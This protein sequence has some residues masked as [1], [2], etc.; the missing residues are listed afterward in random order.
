MMN[1]FVITFILNLIL[2]T[3]NAQRFEGIGD[4]L[5]TPSGD[6]DVFKPISISANGSVILFKNGKIFRNNQIYNL[7]PYKAEGLFY[8][9]F[10]AYP[11]K[12]SSDGTKIVGTIDKLGFNTFSISPGFYRSDF[13]RVACIWDA[14]TLDYKLLDEPPTI[15]LAPTYY[16]GFQN[17]FSS[18]VTN[19]F[20]YGRVTL[21][22]DY[23][24]V[25]N[26]VKSLPAVWSVTDGRL[27]SF[28][29]NT[30]NNT[31][32]YGFNDV[33]DNN[34]GVGNS[35]PS[36]VSK[37]IFKPIGVNNLT[38]IPIN[39][40]ST[41]IKISTDGKVIFG[42]K[43][44]INRSMVYM[45]KD[46][47]IQDLGYIST[48]IYL[49]YYYASAP[50]QSNI[51]SSSISDDGII[52]INKTIW[53]RIK[54][55]RDLEQTLKNDYNLNLTGWSNLSA[56][57][58]SDDGSIIVGLGINP[59]GKVQA[60]KANIKQSV[61]IK[62]YV[63]K[64]D[65]QSNI[66]Q[67]LL[68]V[69]S[70]RSVASNSI[71]LRV[72]ADGSDVSIFK[73]YNVDAANNDDINLRIREQI[74]DN[75]FD[76][77]ARQYG[78]FTSI[79]TPTTEAGTFEFRY[80]HPNVLPITNNS[81]FQN[82][83]LELYK[84]STNEIIGTFPFEVYR[85][86]VLM[87]HGIWSNSSDAF[88]KMYDKL[89]SSGQYDSFLLLNQNYESTNDELFIVN[90]RVI[91]DGIAN[92]KN[93]VISNKSIAVGKVDVVV[94]SMG[95][96]LTRLYLQS[97]EYINRKDIHKFI[98]CNTPHSGSQGANF[99]RTTKVGGVLCESILSQGDCGKGAVDNLQVDSDAILKDLNGSSINKNIVPSHAIATK[100]NVDD[101]IGKFNLIADRV[102]PFEDLIIKKIP[103]LLSKEGFMS[104]HLAIN[105]GSKVAKD[106]TK[107]IFN[108]EESDLV[109]AL[110]SQIGGIDKYT[111][112]NDKQM[113]S[114]ST[115][116]DEL[117][118]VVRGLLNADINGENSKFSLNGFNP[119]KLTYN[120]PSIYKLINANISRTNLSTRSVSATDSLT[121]KITSPLKGSSYRKGEVINLKAEGSTST[122]GLVFLAKDYKNNNYRGEIIANSG[123]YILIPDNNIQ[124]RM[125]L[126]VYAYDTIFQ[127]LAVDTTYFFITNCPSVNIVGNTT[128][129]ADNSTT[130]TASSGASYL[131]STGEVTAAI[132]ISPTV[133]TTYSVTVTDE[134]GCTA[135][136][137]KAI[138][139][140]PS[141]IVNIVIPNTV[142]CAGQFTRNVILSVNTTGSPTPVISYSLNGVTQ[143]PANRP[144]E[145]TQAPLVSTVYTVVGTAANGCVG[146]DT[147]TMTVNPAPQVTLT[148]NTNLCAGQSTTLTATPLGTG[149]Y[150]YRWNNR[151]ETTPSL[152]VT[153]LT[154]RSYIVTV[155]LGVCTITPS[156]TVNV[157]PSNANIS[158]ELV[159]CEGSS[160][161]LSP[162]VVGTYL[163]ST[164]ETTDVIT[165][166][167]SISTDYSITVTDENGCIA[168]DTKT[169]I[170]NPKPT[171]AITGNLTVCA[172]TSTTLTASGGETYLWNTA[173]T[174]S[175]ITVNPTTS[176]TY[177]VSVTDANGCINTASKTVTISPIQTYY[178]DADGDTFGNPSVTVQACVAPV[179]Y[180]ANSGDCNDNNAAI[181]P[182]AIEIC[183]GID[184]NCN[185]QIDE[186][187]APIIVTTPPAN[188]TKIVG[189]TAT[190]SVSVTG[191]AP[192]TYRWFKTSSPTTAI[193]SSATF[194]VASV[195]LSDAGAYQC[196]I[197]NAC[198]SVLS[199]SANLTVNPAC[200]PPPAPYV[201]TPFAFAG[202]GNVGAKAQRRDA[203]FAPIPNLT[204]E[205]YEY[206][207]TQP[208]NQGALI[209]TQTTTVLEPISVYIWN[210]APLATTQIKKVLV[211]EKIGA[212]YSAS[213]EV[214]LTVF[215]KPVNDLS[216]SGAT[217]ACGVVN[218]TA[219][220]ATALTPIQ[221]IEWW[222]N[223][224]HDVNPA[225]SLNANFSTTDVNLNFAFV[226]KNEFRTHIA[227]NLTCY[228][229]G[230]FTGITVNTIP[231]VS[232][233]NLNSN[234]CKN[235]TPITLTGLP[236]NGT[237][238]I[239]GINAT[240]LDPSVLSVGNHVVMYS[241]TDVNGCSN[242]INQTVTIN[243][244]PNVSITNLN[245]NYC[246]NA[247]VITLTGLP[248]NGSFK[249][250]GISATIL[251]PSV[252]S[253][254]N[255]VITYSYTDANGCS[256]SIN[257][258]V[259]IN[260]L[261]T[262][263][264]TNLN[265]NY[266]KNTSTITL[267]GLPINGSFK[268]DG[269]SATI[270]DPSVLSVG[271]HVVTYSFTDANGCFNSI[272]Q[273]VIINALPTVS[274]TNLNSNYCKNATPITLTGLPIN[275][276][277]KIDG[278]SATILDPSVLSVGNHVVTYSYT[279][280]N[281]CSN[282][283][284][285]T[286]TINAQPSISIAAN[287][288]AICAGQTSQLTATVSGVTT[289][290]T[291]SWDNGL[292]NGGLKTTP[293]LSISTTFIAT[294]TTIAG[295]SAT[296][297]AATVTV[298]PPP[299]TPTTTVTQPASCTAS[300]GT[301]TVTAQSNVEYSFDNGSTYQ[302]SNVKT[303]LASGVYQIKV[304]NLTTG[305]V[306][307]A[308]SATIN[309]P[310][311]INVSILTNFAPSYC[312]NNNIVI[313]IQGTPSGGVFKLDGQNLPTISGFSVI[314]PSNLTVGNHILTYNF[315]QNGCTG[316]ATKT[317]V[318]KALPPKP[319][320]QI[321]QVS[322]NAGGS[323][324]ITNLPAGASSRLNNGVW[325]IGKTNYPNLSA[326]TY[327]VRVLN[328]G[329]EESKTVTLN[330]MGFAYDENKCYKIVN[331][332]SGK[333]LDVAG[334]STANNAPII[335]YSLNGVEG[336]ANQKW[337]FDATE[338]GWLKMTVQHSQKVL[339]CNSDKEG[340]NTTQNNY[341]NSEEREWKI[342]CIGSY[343]RI[344]HRESG[345]Y[346]SIEGNSLANSANV[347]IRNWAN[348][349]SQ[350]WSIVEVSCGNPTNNLVA[351]S[352][353]DITAQAEYDRNRITF[354]T[355]QGF[356]TDYYTLEKQDNS[357]GEFKKL[358]ILNNTQLDYTLQDKSMYDD[359][360]QE[361]DNFYRLKMTY[362]T[363]DFDYSP[364]QKVVN[365]KA[366]GFTIF[367]NPA[368]DE[369]WIDLKTFEGR[370]LEI[371]L[372]DMAGKT[373]QV[374]KV[375]KATALP[376]HLDL[377]GI[378]SGTY[379]LNVE[380]K[381]KRTVLRMLSILK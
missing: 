278:I 110:S 35:D 211:Y 245:S 269:I 196:E 57:A 77:F 249:I 127:R 272:N 108:N 90:N 336:T 32:N 177:S 190:F 84:K 16:Y 250:D 337:Q 332:N 36:I 67:D 97:P 259:T 351:R 168:I 381:G 91:P 210:P 119:P 208:N 101:I 144:P 156:I 338:N 313:P 52:V 46:N 56:S 166:N 373:I 88:G 5:Y 227:G 261:P 237:F 375:E 341:N 287:P 242:S 120:A 233:T 136:A 79:N 319:I 38:E 225:L 76:P 359:M 328:A 330:N 3:S 122:N 230:L 305:C 266:C 125:N 315:S 207:A 314:I 282:S 323:I 193:G 47:I 78:I 281:G 358:E 238:K 280:V 62:H 209:L 355:N 114:G 183:D 173:E 94:H 74:L 253:V 339:S 293:P 37:S 82:Y 213:S 30:I 377:T 334:N 29:D 335:Q 228:S 175:S 345:K 182:T 256:N 357:S 212:C 251:D 176:T 112:I 61:I 206:D 248:I 353:F 145:L 342:E 172:G 163:W 298:N 220:P 321:V 279:D 202:C 274:I 24:S 10:S 31:H 129:C 239:D 380:T 204:F 218:L 164:G 48:Q 83:T 310:S 75:N 134:N 118:G 106:L 99:L 291:I 244:L 195:V 179:G 128:V 19:E 324:T 96:I 161:T 165:V 189:Q 171:A 93:K 301:I 191:S 147:K 221:N 246:K 126:I 376:H 73:V 160:T 325:T 348:L 141:P 260:A 200:T 192:L 27:I 349:N 111:L 18:H 103:N 352:V 309:A 360:P 58:I 55:E 149:S 72:C 311:G 231:S 379:I 270:L 109:V 317:I 70:L 9:Y 100:I 333:V 170:V 264:I 362:F 223:A 68:S 203:N 194:S 148:G 142:I 292:G 327:T 39:V 86:P 234:Y 1:K 64:K 354:V 295:C 140:N 368:T 138:T 15:Y 87:A 121:V 197:S 8:D 154:T 300:T 205:W 268:I 294:V 45:Y 363:G 216:I 217:T 146:S 185:G 222:K 297:N 201:G 60:W 158:G 318:I 263:S 241:F 7:K 275:G 157:F 370:T 143:I 240:I 214:E 184:N 89:I 198:G 257:Q 307:L 34:I 326:G 361:G 151:S 65:L 243:A 130:L 322:C 152:T 26:P 267:T 123:S 252:L 285:Q 6:Y 44:D 71:P 12:I 299:T 235:A 366:L 107:L 4:E 131:W 25:T 258:T 283:V 346:L 199:A 159:I 22:N 133:S 117:I 2:I 290:F 340:A 369:A 14:I 284:N 162:R 150:T 40:Q 28:L 102:E 167:P 33:S 95:G 273:T 236:I 155:T 105:G 21:L 304:R 115:S 215:P 276:S 54:G 104:L 306:S 329:C 42:V 153:P 85:A 286:V 271:N 186:G 124:G 169:V 178:A 303:G 51:S 98:P 135:T 53:D 232:I 181:K 308:A 302:V 365:S 374:E 372:T 226:F 49:N 229:D 66:T 69:N 116:N 59:N 113:H 331:R 320:L 224:A 277:F 80:T 367:P 247:S 312:E 265:S 43:K 81:L 17:T 350:Q 137:S 41:A 378:K 174:T 187:Y 139:V 20:I 289:N 11:E 343:F 364:I 219:I 23:N 132:T 13:K 371:V 180:V 347:E 50:Y 63:E 344:K 188:M 254:G 296:S 288:T 356:R 255:H 92:L 262:V 316:V